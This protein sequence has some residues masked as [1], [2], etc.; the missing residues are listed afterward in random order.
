[1]KRLVAVAAASLLV[2]SVATASASAA[3]PKAAAGDGNLIITDASTYDFPGSPNPLVVCI[4]GQDPEIMEVGGQYFV[5]EPAPSTIEVTVFD[6]DAAT[7]SDTPDRSISVPLAEGVVQGLVIGWEDL[8]TFTYNTD[9]VEAGDARVLLAQGAYFGT[10]AAVDVYAF[11]EDT[12][13][14]IPLAQGFEPGTARYA[15]DI[16]AGTYNFEIFASGSATDGPP[17]AEV[18]VGDL[19]EGTFTQAFLAGGNDGEA[20]GF[21]F[22]QGPEVCADEEPPTTT[23]SVPATTTTAPAEVAPGQAVAATPVSGTATFTG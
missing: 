18:P 13:D 6:N 9:C 12:G 23:S 4:D 20:G 7:C 16:P 21:M 5:E 15:P 11:S 2:V 3:Q 17:L 10:D 19:A 22:Q 14:L 8:F 1:M